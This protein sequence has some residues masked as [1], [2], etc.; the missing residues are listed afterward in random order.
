MNY[1]LLWTVYHE[2]WYI[3]CQHVIIKDILIF[4]IYVSHNHVRITESVMT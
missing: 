2:D 1:K 4:Q 3:F